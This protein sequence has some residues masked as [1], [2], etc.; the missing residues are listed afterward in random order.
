MLVNLAEFFID[1]DRAKLITHCYNCNKDIDVIESIL[2]NLPESSRF[3][4]NIDNPLIEIEIN[5]RC[6]NCKYQFRINRLRYL[7][8]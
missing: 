6:P 3:L 4:P 1:G 7:E 8:K 2:H 5:L